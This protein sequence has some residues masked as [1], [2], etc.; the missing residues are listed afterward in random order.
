MTVQIRRPVPSD[1]EI[2]QETQLLPIRE[3]AHRLGVLDEEL[4]LHGPFMAKIDF[5]AV[6]RRLQNRRHG[7]F[8]T[9]TAITPTPLGEGKTVTSLGIG[10]ALA[11]LGHS[12]CNVLREPSKGPTFG[13]KGGACGG[14]YSQML[15]MEQINLHLTGDIHAVESAQNLCAAAIDASLLHGNPLGIDPLTVTWPRCVDVNDRA[16]RDIVIGLGGRAN[17][18]PRQ[19]GYCITAASETAA[20]HSLARDLPDLRARLSRIVVGFTREGKP[21]TA[22]DLR[23]AGAMTALLLDAIKPNLVQSTENHPVIVHGFPFANV[24]HGNSSVVGALTALKLAD[25][26]VTESGFGSDCG[27]AKLMDV[28][29][30]QTPGLQVDCAVIVATVRAL[31]QHGGAFRLRPGMPYARVKEAAERENLP[32]VEAGC[33]TNLAAHIRIVRTYGVPVVVA[34]NRFATDTDA[35]LDLVRALA[36]ELGADD[37][38]VHDAWGLGGEGAIDLARAVVRVT[39]QPVENRFFYA[40]DAPITEKIEATATL[41]YGADGV[42]YTPLA[43]ERIKLYTDLGYQTL[44]LNMAKTHLSLSDDSTLMGAPTGWRLTVRDLRACVGAGF[45]YPLA[46][47]FPTMPG[48]PSRPAFMAVDVDLKT[49]KITGLF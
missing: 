26:V 13:I 40:S 36:V 19:T 4:E 14:G 15:P 12:V 44:T 46:G 11:R 16:L 2:A 3:V 21:V 6:L 35:E 29:I 27:F 18:Y 34:I 39:E 42:D 20:I 7:K 8:I 37:A 41:L 1:L 24:A 17:G 43:R 25:Y 49:G 38:V 9:V 30:R 32:A 31:K 45:L 48:L 33:R 5:A 47:D 23:V 22:E 10:Q 28:V